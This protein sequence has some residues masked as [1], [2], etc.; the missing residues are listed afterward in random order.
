MQ[1]TISNNLTIWCRIIFGAVLIICLSISPVMG[2]QGIS[3][4]TNSILMSM[5]SYMAKLDSFSLKA[6][7]D[8]GIVTSNGQKIQLS[9]FATLLMERSSKLY[10][11][12][13]G[14]VADAQFIYDGKILTL[15]GKNFNIYSQTKIPG[16]IDD[17]FRG[18]E[19][20]SGISAP[21]L[22]KDAQARIG[23]PLTP[24]SFAGVARRT[25]RRVCDQ[26]ALVN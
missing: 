14:M 23:R 20:V 24:G 11:T 2:D 13:K 25:T 8:L 26:W 4:E 1:K 3:P 15:H 18:Y 19:S 10:I 7:I 5:S 6:D 22:M 9:S 16:T 17:A 12:R 21:G